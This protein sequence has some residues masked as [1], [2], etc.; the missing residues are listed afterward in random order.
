MKFVQA[1]GSAP[2][3]P[4]TNP[5]IEI[6]QVDPK[7]AEKWLSG[8]VRN[9]KLKPDRITYYAREM[10]A[11]RW[12]FTGEAIQFDANGVLLN[13]QHRLHSII[14]SGVTVPLAVVRNLEPEAQVV[15]DSGVKRT[16]ADTLTINGEKNATLL[17]GALR[18]AVVAERSVPPK[19]SDP[20]SASEAQAFLHEHPEI[21]EAVHLSSKYGLA[22]DAPSRSVLAYTAWRTMLIDQRET[23]KFLEDMAEKVGLAR[24][25]PALVLSKKWAD[26]RRK[27]ELVTI[28]EQVSMTFR[29]WNARRK[30]HVLSIV[31]RVNQSGAPIPIP[32]PL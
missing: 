16:I 1:V 7:L 31:K 24:N 18:L 3:V 20:V 26:V 8:N 9:R 13:G 21:R 11:G 15:M 4:E 28:P 14:K 12:S 5:T 29:A 19:W 27:R 2:V 30:G 10:A 6:V 17:A 22:A 32:E 23:E 25:D